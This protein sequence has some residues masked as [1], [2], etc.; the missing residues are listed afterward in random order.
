MLHKYKEYYYKEDTH[1]LV[2]TNCESCDVEMIPPNRLCESCI[3]NGQNNDIFER[4][5]RLWLHHV[6]KPWLKASYYDRMIAEP[7][8]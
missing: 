3:V 2:L 8:S 5:K 7:T 6:Y 1:T 4:Q